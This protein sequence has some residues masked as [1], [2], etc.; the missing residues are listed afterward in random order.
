MGRIKT[1]VPRSWKAA[2]E[3]G[4]GNKP[5][6]FHILFFLMLLCRTQETW[7]VWPNF[8]FACVDVFIYRTKHERILLLGSPLPEWRHRNLHRVQRS[9]YQQQLQVSGALFRLPPNDRTLAEDPIEQMNSKDMPAFKRNIQKS[10]Q[11]ISHVPGAGIRSC[12]SSPMCQKT[13]AYT[14]QTPWKNST[15]TSG[16]LG[17]FMYRF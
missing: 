6:N 16:T 9:S 10:A 17:R 8:L 15:V 5:P 3:E 11:K 12:S 4:G 1:F 14:W 13:L 7:D 2:V